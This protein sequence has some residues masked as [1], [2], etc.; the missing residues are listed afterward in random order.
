MIRLDQNHITAD[1][2]TKEDGAGTLTH[3]GMMMLRLHRTC[4]TSSYLVHFLR[5]DRKPAA[6]LLL[7]LT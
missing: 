6:S 2:G 1:H 7:S 5:K 4:W 3:G